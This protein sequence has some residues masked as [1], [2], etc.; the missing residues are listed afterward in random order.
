MMRMSYARFAAMV[1]TSFAVMY[2]LMYLNTFRASHIEFSHTA[3]AVG[4]QETR[5]AALK[6]LR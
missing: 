3:M 2:A 4:R 5:D 1:G 6:R